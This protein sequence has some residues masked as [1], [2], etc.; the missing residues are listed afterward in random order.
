[1]PWCCWCLSVRWP[2]ECPIILH[3]ITQ[4]APKSKLKCIWT[5]LAINQ[6]DFG[7]TS[8][9]ATEQIEWTRLQ[10]LGFVFQDAGGGPHKTGTSDEYRNDCH[11]G[12]A[13]ECRYSSGDHRRC[14]LP[15]NKWKEGR[16]TTMRLGYWSLA[17]DGMGRRRDLPV[18]FL[19]PNMFLLP[20][21]TPPPISL[22]SL[23]FF[24]AYYR[25]LKGLS[26]LQVSLS[27]SLSSPYPWV[28]ASPRTIAP[29][30]DRAC[31][32]F[33]LK[34]GKDRVEMV[35]EEDHQRSV[36]AVL[37]RMLFHPHHSLPSTMI[38]SCPNTLKAEFNVTTNGATLKLKAAIYAVFIWKQSNRLWEICPMKLL[39]FF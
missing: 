16:K 24:Q 37:F 30:A 10:V 38:L 25:H 39:S 2:V 11:G 27:L 8:G 29:A 23:L 17:G 18:L 3:Y 26:P 31:W 21:P 12:M 32:A 1:M 13:N 36:A 35:K 28:M 20:A 14:L 9:A 7:P 4:R 22:D 19:K 6:S 5:N 33:S 15:K 34:V